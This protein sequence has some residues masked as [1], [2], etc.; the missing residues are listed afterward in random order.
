M[1]GSWSDKEKVCPTYWTWRKGR[2][3]QGH[4]ISGPAG[5][6]QGSAQAGVPT[7][8]TGL[9]AQWGGTGHSPRILPLLHQGCLGCLF[10]LKWGSGGTLTVTRTPV[11]SGKLT[12]DLAPGWRLVTWWCLPSP[13]KTP[14]PRRGAGAQREPY[15]YCKQHRCRGLPLM[16]G[17][18]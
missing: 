13:S 15:G 4:L 10:P 1:Q 9:R 11:P 17:R 7:A 8:E 18:L 6:L 16:G 5:R 14:V 2:S 3:L 12:R